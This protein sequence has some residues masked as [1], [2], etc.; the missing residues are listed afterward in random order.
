MPSLHSILVIFQSGE[1]HRR[2]VDTALYIPF[3]LYSN[4]RKDIAK[5]LDE[6]NFTFHSGYILILSISGKISFDLL[7]IPFWLYSNAKKV[8]SSI[9]LYILYIPFWLYS[10]K[11]VLDAIEEMPKA[12]HSILV[13][14]QFWEY[15]APSIVLFLYIPFWLYSNGCAIIKSHLSTVLY[16]PFWLYSNKDVLLVRIK[17]KNFTFH[18]G[19][20]PMYKYLHPL[21]KFFLY[22]PFWLYSNVYVLTP[23]RVLENPLHSILVIFQ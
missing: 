23:V 21:S 16:I 17:Q 11:D 1:E 7:Y 8:I 18:S 3:W 20:I 10:N 22:I 2:R 9:R 14:F 4:D 13:I 5:S 19:Y 12:L 6:M 15:P